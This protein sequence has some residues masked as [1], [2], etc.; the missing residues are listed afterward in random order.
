MFITG[1][2]DLQIIGVSLNPRQQTQND[3]PENCFD[4]F[5]STSCKTGRDGQR[6]NHAVSAQLSAEADIKS[7]T[8]YTPNTESQLHNFKVL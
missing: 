4:S 7:V 6:S 1:L 5:L 3:R 2:E 8:V